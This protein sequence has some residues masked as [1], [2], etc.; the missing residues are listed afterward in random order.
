GLAAY[1]RRLS[2]VSRGLV[3]RE[4]I[5]STEG[6]QDRVQQIYQ[7]LLVRPADASG[8]Q[9]YSDVLI[10]G[11]SEAS[12]IESLASSSESWSQPARK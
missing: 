7:D 9:T 5:S 8:L 10:H 2:T 12:I 4:F 6:S 11:G 1:G 3:A